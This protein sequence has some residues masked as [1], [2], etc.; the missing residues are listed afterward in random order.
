MAQGLEM[1]LFDVIRVS[2]PEGGKFF[3]DGKLVAEDTTDVILRKMSSPQ[4]RTKARASSSGVLINGRVYPGSRMKASVHHFLQDHGKPVLDRHPNPKDRY[5]AP[6]R[7]GRVVAAEYVQT[8]VDA[9]W[10]NDWKSP[11]PN[12]SAGSGHIMIDSVISGLEN[13]ERVLDKR[14]LSL[15]VGFTPLAYYCSICGVDWVQHG[16]PCGHEPM[17]VYEVEDARKG[18]PRLCFNITGNLLYD[19]VANVNFP[20]DPTAQFLTAEFQ[21]H[22]QTKTLHSFLADAYTG[23]LSA[24]L[25]VDAASQR[26]LELQ[27]T[28]PESPSRVFSSVGLPGHGQKEARMGQPVVEAAAKLDDKLTD[29]GSVKPPPPAAQTAPAAKP[30]TTDPKPAGSAADFGSVGNWTG[31]DP[32]DGHTHSLAAL[33]ADGSGRTTPGGATA[34]DH[35]IKSGRVLPYSNGK[36]GGEAY[37]SRHPGTYYYDQAGKPAIRFDD[38]AAPVGESCEPC[39]EFEKDD[40]LKSEFTPTD[41]KKIVVEKMDA[42]EMADML[43]EHELISTGKLKT[44]AVLTAA[45]RKKIPTGLFCGPGRSF[46]VHDKAHVRNALSRLPQSTRF[47]PEQKAR[48][49]ACIKRRAKQLG[50]EAGSGGDEKALGQAFMDGPSQAIL[51]TLGQ[52]LEAR[53][54]RIGQLEGALTERSDELKR[55]KA[56]HEKAQQ[57]NLSLLLDRI[58][59]MKLILGKPDMQTV[60]AEDDVKKFKTELAKRSLD[61]LRDS[62]RDLQLELT[63]GGSAGARPSPVLAKPESGVGGLGGA[64][65]VKAGDPGVTLADLALRKLRGEA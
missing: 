62:A 1:R 39:Y 27:L 4:I 14:D 54:A 60:K 11:T 36:N 46:P 38:A 26:T 28:M 23:A 64:P 51:K 48:I 42:D 50:V 8:A 16:G 49:L 33:N 6:T 40:S 52:D 59:D 56:A 9:L 22:A 61:S 10:Q 32:V 65:T 21:D 44:D 35:E 34:H 30:P 53:I 5:D 57:E 17:K 20:A 47:S 15:S 7:V 19:H 2:L 31:P 12:G 24:L 58:I 13:I 37:M 45:A 25:L 55:E 3:C 41:D 18:G 43:E 63:R 29:A